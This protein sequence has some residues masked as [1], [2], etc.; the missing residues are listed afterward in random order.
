MY[1]AL[2]L[3]ND[4]NAQ[5]LVETG[6]ARHGD[7]ACGSEGCS[8]LILGLYASASGKKLYSVDN[9][10]ESCKMAES[11]TL[12]Y[13][14]SVQ[15]VKNDAVEYLDKFDKGFIDFL[16]LDSAEYSNVNPTSAQNYHL[17]EI[18]AAYGKLHQ[19]SI[20]MISKCEMEPECNCALVKDFLLQRRWKQLRGGKTYIF[21]PN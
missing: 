18:Q 14:D 4:R 21:T 17:K 9:N 16:Y 1:E 6:T 15:V 2:L 11:F 13:K 3:M 19:K 7:R 5:V 8:T 12:N 10:E 20:V